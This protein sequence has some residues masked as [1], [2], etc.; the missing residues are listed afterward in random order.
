MAAVTWLLVV[1]EKLQVKSHFF[2]S[3][4]SLFYEGTLNLNV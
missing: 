2:V 4:F 1:R 3:G